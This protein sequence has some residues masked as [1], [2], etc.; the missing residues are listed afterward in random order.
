MTKRT[1]LSVFLVVLVIGAIIPCS[2]FL[3][4]HNCDGVCINPQEPC[5]CAYKSGYYL[6]SYSCACVGGELRWQECHYLPAP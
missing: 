2:L 4:G 1:L 6:E 5:C 3:T